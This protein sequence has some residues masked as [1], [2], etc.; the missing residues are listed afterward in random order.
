MNH[1]QY[2]TWVE[3]SSPAHPIPGHHLGGVGSIDQTE[4]LRRTKSHF[5]SYTPLLLRVRVARD[6]AGGG[7]EPPTSD[8]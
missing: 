6:D 3:G 4:V 2:P 8:Y 1:S 5:C 7:I